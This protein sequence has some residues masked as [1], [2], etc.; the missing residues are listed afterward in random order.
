MIRWRGIG[1]LT[2][3]E[4]WNLLSSDTFGNSTFLRGMSPTHP[5]HNAMHSRASSLEINCT[6]TVAIERNIADEPRTLRT[7]FMVFSLSSIA[8]WNGEKTKKI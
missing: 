7:F 4:E 2:D 5:G 6:P 1:A 8:H 3:Y